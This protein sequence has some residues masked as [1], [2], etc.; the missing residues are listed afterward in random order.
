VQAQATEEVE[1]TTKKP[2][3]RKSK[4][5][6]EETSVAADVGKQVAKRAAIGEQDNLF[7]EVRARI[8]L[9]LLPGSISN[10]GVCLCVRVRVSDHACVYVWGGIVQW[11]LH[12]LV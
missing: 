6:V 2:K 12:A 11:C 7:R 8:P 9:K 10:I 4:A 3:A 1:A 5:P